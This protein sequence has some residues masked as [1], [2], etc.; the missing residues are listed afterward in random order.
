MIDYLAEGTETH[1]TDHGILCKENRATL[2]CVLASFVLST[3]P[4]LS[5]VFIAGK[6]A[7]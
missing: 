6:A 1:E 2:H 7:S 5:N 3:L 4:D